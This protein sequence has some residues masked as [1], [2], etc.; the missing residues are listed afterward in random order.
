MSARDDAAFS[1]AGAIIAQSKAAALV[2]GLYR[3]LIAGVRGSRSL[4]AVRQCRDRF[5]RIPAAERRR[6]VAIAIAAACA[7]HVVMALFEP[8]RARPAITLT[9]L[10]LLALALA[11]IAVANQTSEP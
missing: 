4:A 9:A 1:G 5:Q 6:C 7:G 3:R 10:A 2:D 11:A 8:A